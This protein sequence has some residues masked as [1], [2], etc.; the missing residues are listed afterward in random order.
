MVWFDLSPRVVAR[1]RWRRNMDFWG[2]PN[3]KPKS[4]P[5]PSEKVRHR[6]GA[7]PRITAGTILTIRV[8]SPTI[9]S[10][11]RLARRT[12]FYW[13]VIVKAGTIRCAI[14][15]SVGSVSDPKVLTRYSERLIVT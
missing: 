9:R 1:L 15:R 12:P 13:L 4:L 6:H 2:G 8:R 11:N 5:A 3:T 7:R 14:L 10:R